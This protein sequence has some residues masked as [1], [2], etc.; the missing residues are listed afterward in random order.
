MTFLRPLMRRVQECRPCR[1]SW[2]FAAIVIGTS[3][4]YSPPP[5]WMHIGV[6]K[7]SAWLRKAQLFECPST[8]E[9]LAYGEFD[10]HRGSELAIIL[11]DPKDSSG[12]TKNIIFVDMSGAIKGTLMV[13]CDPARPAALS[14]IDV[15]GDGLCEFLQSNALL[16][17]HDGRLLATL[18]EPWNDHVRPLDFDHNGVLDFY[19]SNGP[20]FTV[21][22]RDG[23]LLHEF[24]IE[25]Y[26]YD[27][28]M[29]DFDGDRRWDRVYV[30][31]KEIDYQPY[32]YKLNVR[33][34]DGEISRTIEKPRGGWA[35]SPFPGQAG[36]RF[37]LQYVGEELH[38]LPFDGS[39][40]IAQLE[41]V[42]LSLSG[43]VAEVADF[44]ADREFLIV[45]Q[46]YKHQGRLVGFSDFRLFLYL[47]DAEGG[48][49]YS[50]VLDSLYGTADWFV[51]VAPGEGDSPAALFVAEGSIVWRYSV[52]Q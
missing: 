31:R 1:H 36:R 20:R 24:A 28:R 18:S 2:I 44:D 9:S 6:K 52:D 40:A 49:V 42:S 30:T 17:A 27:A 8:I 3:G 7:D 5:Q 38:V 51:A 11:S 33:S 35:I 22:N 25:A 26:L 14:I 15:D 10:G 41:P 46:H 39:P 34:G 50:E 23:K 48:L 29:I 21:V 43:S 16:L 12:Q 47:F 13:R 37:L 4:C 19:S 45:A 32:E